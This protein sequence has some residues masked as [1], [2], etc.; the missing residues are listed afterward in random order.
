VRH[1]TLAHLAADGGEHEVFVVQFHSEHGAGEHE[2]HAAF[3]FNVFFFHD[4]RKWKRRSPVHP[5]PAVI[6]D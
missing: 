5:N 6:F 1:E 2:L 3:D 4:W